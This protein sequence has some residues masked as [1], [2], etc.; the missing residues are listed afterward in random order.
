LREAL[1]K[2]FL[3]GVGANRT[4]FMEFT[5]GRQIGFLADRFHRPAA[6]TDSQLAEVTLRLQGSVLRWDDF[7]HRCHWPL[8]VL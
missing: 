1:S 7:R 2:L 4:V 8:E 3:S 5:D 6:A